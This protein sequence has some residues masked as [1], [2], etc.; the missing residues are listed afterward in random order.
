[1]SHLVWDIRVLPRFSPLR[2]Y[3]TVIAPL[4]QSLWH[5]SLRVTPG[6]AP[7]RRFWLS[8]TLPTSQPLPCDAC[9][10]GNAACGELRALLELVSPG[11]RAAPAPANST[12]GSS[13]DRH[14][15]TPSVAW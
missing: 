5:R 2:L 1:M 9:G 4:R 15:V 6:G 13:W 7:T 14:V 8:P 12:R 10:G 3:L 11:R